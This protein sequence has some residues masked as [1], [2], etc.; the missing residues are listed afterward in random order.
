MPY[1]DFLFQA[2]FVLSAEEA[3]TLFVHT[4]TV[5]NGLILLV[6]YRDRNYQCD[7]D[8]LE[9]AQRAAVH[10]FK[11]DYRYL[12][13]YYLYVERSAMRILS[14]SPQKSS[15]SRR[16]KITNGIIHVD[17]YN[18]LPTATET[19]TRESHDFNYYI[20]HINNNVSKYSYFPKTDRE[21]NSLSPVISMM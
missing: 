3:A 12:I 4:S 19:P 5:S 9:N 7:T 17:K 6:C 10:F 20:E 21:W 1:Y 14:L 8:K 18:Y 2:T 11:G 13:K 15:L 16:Y